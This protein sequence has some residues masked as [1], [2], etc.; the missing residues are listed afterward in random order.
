ML[1]SPLPDVG[2]RCAVRARTYVG[3]SKASLSSLNCF[4]T[5]RGYLFVLCR[6]E[7]GR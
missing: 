6:C 1:F 2:S 5:G 3:E 4:S 7:V